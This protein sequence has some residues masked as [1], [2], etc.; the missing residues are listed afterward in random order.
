M[1][2]HRI[3][4]H[5]QNNGQHI[6]LQAAPR[7]R[8][9]ARRT[10][11]GKVLNIGVGDGGLERIAA[12]MG[13]DVYSLDPGWEAL[14]KTSKASKGAAGGIEA[15]PFKDA[16]FDTV[17]CS[18]VLEHLNDGSL[19]AGLDEINRVTKRGG[20]FIG[21]V[22]ADEVISESEVVCP[23]CGTVFHRWGHVQSFSVARL[24]ALLG[25]LGTVQIERRLFVRWSSLNWKGKIAAMLRIAMSSAGLHAGGQNLYFHVLKQG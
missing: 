11:A 6:F 10:R 18:E 1:E 13:R 15:L 22:P 8:F 5:F 12:E 16:V 24:E 19:H 23:C 25:K 7:Y 20:S 9:L 4:S 17:V 21:T 2:Q 14:V 3:W